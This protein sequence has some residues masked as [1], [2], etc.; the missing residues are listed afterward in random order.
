MADVVLMGDPEEEQKKE[1]VI[2]STEWPP[3]SIDMSKWT[4]AATTRESNKMTEAEIWHM[5]DV[6]GMEGVIAPADYRSRY[7]ITVTHPAS[8]LTPEENQKIAK[9]IA[10]GMK[11]G[12][13]ISVPVESQY[14]RKF[15]ELT[16]REL[17]N[18]LDGS[19]FTLVSYPN[20]SIAITKQEGH[21]SPFRTKIG[22][23]LTEDQRQRIVAIL[24][25][26]KE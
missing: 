14:P 10:D 16:V 7:G 8:Q 9:L 26:P 4:V 22:K 15:N 1:I 12:Q 13:V 25:E 2:S 20:T 18:L 5:T 23:S 3:P 17:W 11:G 24:E 19:D 21:P 6:E